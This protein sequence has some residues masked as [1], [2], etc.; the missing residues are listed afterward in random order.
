MLEPAEIERQAR[1]L[2]NYEAG[3]GDRKRWMRS[4][5]FSPR[6][7]RRILRS[8]PAARDMAPPAGLVQLADRTRHFRERI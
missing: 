5:S 8:L 3:G 4:K 2:A 6:D 7:R 1:Q